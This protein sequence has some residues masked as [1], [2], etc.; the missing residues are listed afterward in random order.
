MA[1]I[2]RREGAVYRPMA[3]H[4]FPPEYED[5][6]KELSIAPSRGTV[7]GRVALERRPVQ[8]ADVTADLEYDIHRPMGSG[9]LERCWAF[10][11]CAKMCR[12]A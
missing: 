9:K 1:F 4:G 3:N 6:V 11:C 8:I 7:T 5:F 10:H 12:S 2:L